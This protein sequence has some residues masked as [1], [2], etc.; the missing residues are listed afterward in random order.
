MN[1]VGDECNSLLPIRGT[2][3][4][5]VDGTALLQALTAGSVNL[6]FQTVQSP[7][8]YFGIDGQGKVQQTGW[9]LYPSFFFLIWQSQW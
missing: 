4:S 9:L 8:F 5:Y 1:C 3:I 7:A 6:T 2:M